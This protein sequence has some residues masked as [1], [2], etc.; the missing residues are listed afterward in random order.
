MRA[1]DG[2]AQQVGQGRA[3]GRSSA[4]EAGA[5]AAQEFMAGDPC[6]QGVAL[7]CS[8]T[9][10]VY[11]TAYNRQM[12]GKQAFGGPWAGELSESR[13]ALISRKVT[14]GHG[15]GARLPARNTV[16][17]PRPRRTL[18]PYPCSSV[19]SVSSVIQTAKAKA[20]A[21]LAFGCPK[22]TWRFNHAFRRCRANEMA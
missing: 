15:V 21:E 13:L 19:P 12:G 17:I 1:S 5:H 14:D 7:R 11:P 2:G 9:E 8:C 6:I 10:I 3:V 20:G 18:F 16:P 22:G 4:W